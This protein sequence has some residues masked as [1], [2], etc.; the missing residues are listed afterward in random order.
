MEDKNLELK[1]IFI[2][3]TTNHQEGNYEIA[4]NLYKKILKTKPENINVMN[5]LATLYIQT[6]Y[7][8]MALNILQNLLK[9]EPN[10]LKANSSLGITYTHL[11]EYQK[12]IECHKKVIETEPKNADEYNNIGINYNH[13]GESDLASNYF[14]KAI[15]NNSKHANAYNNLG[16]LLG[17][18]GKY[19]KSIAALKKSLEFEPDFFKAQSNIT[20][21]YI[22]QLNS[23]EK[24]VSESHKT[25]NMHC[26]ISK[27]YEQNVHLF[28]FKHDVG[29]AEYLISKN[30]KINGLNEFYKVGKEILERAENIENENNSNKV[31]S[32]NENEVKYC[33]TYYKAQNIYQT[34]ILPENLLN[35]TK[36][37]KKV[38]R[39]YF[40]S[41][42]QII[43]IDNFLSEEAVKELREFC[44]VSKVWVHQM[45]NKYLGAFGDSGF[46]SPLHFKIATELQKKLPKLFGKYNIGKFWGF[47]YDTSLGGGIGVHADF[48]YL[49]L[50][51]WITP[52]QY[53]NDKNSGGLKVYNVPAPDDWS[54]NKYNNRP[55]DIY[56][57]LDEKNADCEIIP[58]RFNRAVLFNSAY[59]HETDKIDFKEGYESRRINIT[60]LFGSRQI[61]KMK[62]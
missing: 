37:W 46:A 16:I 1:E 4:E 8:K 21:V 42:N 2:T 26:K 12:A 58:Y 13:L 36:D 56:K 6:G 32:L 34:P 41:K 44:L 43:F 29:Q 61:K 31:I 25:L 60:Y 35:P 55:K 14:H 53:N 24:A 18:Q 49:N 28:R 50:N 59:F 48:A 45:R 22:N 38:E 5:N 30:Y 11:F 19:E 51:F 17:E 23:I 40:N 3:A 20:S 47:K 54:F 52:D 57:F 10:N 9:N 39:E 62:N 7:A 27:V 33:L 15:E